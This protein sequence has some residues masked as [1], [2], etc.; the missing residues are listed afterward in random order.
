MGVCDCGCGRELKGRG[1]GTRQRFFSPA[2]RMAYHNLARREGDRLLQRRVKRGKGPKRPRL[3][4]ADAL[5]M[6]V[7]LALE[8]CYPGGL[9]VPTNESN[10]AEAA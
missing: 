10:R 8:T 3:T 4:L 9:E 6:G 2:C 5:K 7:I 1:R